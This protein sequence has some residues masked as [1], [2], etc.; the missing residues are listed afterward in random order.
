MVVKMAHE[1]R[2]LQ[3][4]L[5]INYSAIWTRFKKKVSNEFD[6]IYL[7]DVSD[8]LSSS[9]NG[10]KKYCIDISKK[11]EKEL[12]EFDFNYGGIFYSDPVD[13]PEERNT[14]LN[15]KENINKFSNFVN[16]VKLLGEGDGPE[17]WYGAYDIAVNKIKW[18]NGIRCIIHITDAEAHGTDYCPEDKYPEEGQKLDNLIPKCAEMNFQIFGFKIG[19]NAD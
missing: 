2:P 16:D 18:R 4:V 9:L 5:N 1:F 6:L 13:V 15:L 7:V 14:Y 19:E 3:I 8:S 10:V 17:D 11:I 12:P